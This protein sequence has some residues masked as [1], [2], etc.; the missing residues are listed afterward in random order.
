MLYQLSYAPVRVLG[1]LVA[2]AQPG[3]GMVLE[4]MGLDCG[5]VGLRGVEPRTS[6]LSGGRSNQL[7][8][9]PA[10][11]RMRLLPPYLQFAVSEPGPGIRPA[12]RG[13]TVGTDF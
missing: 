9:R 8:Y 12:G 11:P 6:R 7:S 5:V 3:P 13:T 10:N 2:H 4:F 1:L